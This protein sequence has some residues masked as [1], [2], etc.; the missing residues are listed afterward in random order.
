[1]RRDVCKASVDIFRTH[2]RITIRHTNSVPTVPVSN[3]L[4]QAGHTLPS[5][6][7]FVLQSNFKTK[8]VRDI[9]ESYLIC[10]FK[11]K[12]NQGPR[13]VP[14]PLSIASLNNQTRLFF[15][16]NSGSGPWSLCFLLSFLPLCMLLFCVC[17]C[18]PRFPL[19]SGPS[20][21]PSKRIQRVLP[22]LRN[23][24]QLCNRIQ[25]AITSI[26]LLHPSAAKFKPAPTHS[27]SNCTH[28]LKLK[29]K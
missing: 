1:M 15:I 2:F 5:C 9:I 12:I 18:S 26:V 28:S 11:C 29:Q 14:S 24:I 17:V 16:K 8:Q 7:I 20:H 3:N 6:F 22:I 25:R 23:Y 13:A 4:I 21:S 10:K 19:V 27:T